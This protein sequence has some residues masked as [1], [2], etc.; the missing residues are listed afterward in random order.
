M[1][2]PSNRASRCVVLA[3][4]TWDYLARLEGENMVRQRVNARIA[5]EKLAR[6]NEPLT[7][8]SNAVTGI[9]LELN[10]PFY[11]LKGNAA[12]LHLGTIEGLLQYAESELRRA[13]KASREAW[14]LLS[15]ARLTRYQHELNAL[16][17][18]ANSPR[19]AAWQ[20]EISRR[21]VGDLPLNSTAT[22]AQ[23]S[24]QMA[25]ATQKQ[26]EV[27][28]LS[29]PTV[30]SSDWVVESGGYLENIATA[31]RLLVLD[32]EMST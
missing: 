10:Q 20:R 3:P 1:F 2:S 23:L 32:L 14:H 5:L 11:K 6:I 21:F 15:H 9:L 13:D 31:L 22:P 25:L 19:F 4:I 8:A 26:V 18:D 30:T 7:R 27:S 28:T 17:P 16:V 12:W 24:V 29:L